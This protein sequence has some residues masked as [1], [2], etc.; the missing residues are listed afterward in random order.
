MG[1]KMNPKPF[2]LALT[3][4]LPTAQL[5]NT[6]Y[7]YITTQSEELSASGAALGFISRKPRTT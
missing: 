5:Q 6:H 7:Q 3:H 1:K 2:T 4:T